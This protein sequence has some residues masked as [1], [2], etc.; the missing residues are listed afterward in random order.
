VQLPG[1]AGSVRTSGQWRASG[2]V[3]TDTPMHLLGASEHTGT[4]FEILGST[5]VAITLVVLL[6]VATE[7][8]PGIWRPV[9]AVG[10]MGLTVYTLH[11]VAIGALGLRSGPGEP[12]HILPMSVGGAIVFALVWTRFV[13]RGPLE[14]LLHVATA[15]AARLGRR[16][17]REPGRRSR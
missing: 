2:V 16:D 9:A 1:P 8:R 12:A 11:V 13:R 5:G 10:T 7:R 15:P 14:Q 3:E 4:P 17:E 6:L